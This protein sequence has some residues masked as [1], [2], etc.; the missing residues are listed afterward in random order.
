MVLVSSSVAMPFKRH[1]QRVVDVYISI[2]HE[3]HV[4]ENVV[5]VKELIIAP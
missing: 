2:M 4:N 3:Y 5:N 1:Q